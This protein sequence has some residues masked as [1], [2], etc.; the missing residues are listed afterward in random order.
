MLSLYVTIYLT[1]EQF[2]LLKSNK[3][4][5]HPVTASHTY[6]PGRINHVVL[7]SFLGYN[8]KINFNSTTTQLIHA[9]K[10]GIIR[11]LLIHF[12]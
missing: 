3:N 6:R 2:I 4:I 10:K 1:N 9:I 8:F 7:C 5:K 12:L 11:I